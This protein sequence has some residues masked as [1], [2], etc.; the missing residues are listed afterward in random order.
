[1]SNKGIQLGSSRE[2]AEKLEEAVLPPSLGFLSDVQHEQQSLG[3]HVFEIDDRDYVR[4]LWQDIKKSE[5]ISNAQ[6]RSDATKWTAEKKNC[7]ASLYER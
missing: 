4:K 5:A 1:M 7:L 3:H 6:N 2:L